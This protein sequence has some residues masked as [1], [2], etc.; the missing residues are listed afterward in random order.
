M[1][2]LIAGISGIRGIVGET[3]LP[4]TVLRYAPAFAAWCGGGAIV[5]GYDGRPSG[6]PLL[7]LVRGALQLA[8]ADVIDCGVVPTPTVQLAVEHASARGGIVVTASHNPAPWNGLKFLGPDG[9]FLDAEQNAAFFALAAAG[10]A[11][12]ADWTSLGHLTRDDDAIDRHIARVLET[13]PLDVP[14]IRA[15]GLRVAVDA[16][17]AAGSRAVPD[18]LARLGCTVV[19]VACDGSG[20]FPHTP[21]PLP[22]NLVTLGE[23]VRASGADLGMAIDPDADRLVLFDE[24]GDPFGEEYTITIALHALLSSTA[25]TGART[26]AVN[27]STTRAV[28]DVARRSG[29]VVH[30]APVGE[31]NVVKRMRAVNAVAGGEGSGGVI[32]PAVHAGRDALVGAALVLQALAAHGGSASALRASMPDYRIRKYKYDAAGVDRATAFA[33]VRAAFCAERINDEDGIRID[34]EAGWVHLRA[35]NTEPI[36]RVIAEAATADAAD[37]LAAR[38]A[39]EAFGAGTVPL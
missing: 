37:A 15:L 29:A 16:V 27:L 14:R 11:P 10:T 34:F 2:Q 3:L 26:V 1:G 36:V 20:V 19:P 24:R 9:V 6:A 31:I 33:R 25:D 35:S 17:N 5:V 39:D 7:D 28:D 30:R 23:A 12:R 18:L 21:E 32:V 38:V 8:G 13:L 4:E 22:E